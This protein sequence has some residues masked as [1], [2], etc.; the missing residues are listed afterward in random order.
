M[1]QSFE[2][3]RLLLREV[4]PSDDQKM[5]EL[6]SNPEVHRFLGNKPVKSILESR[7]MIA[8]IHW[9]YQQ[10]GIGRWA[11]VLK[12]TNEFIG[13]SG[14]KLEQNVNG[15]KQ[16]FDLG[17]RFIQQYWGKGYALEAALAFVEYGFN[18]LHIDTICAFTYA[19]NLASRKVLE[20]AGLHCVEKFLYDESDAIWYEIH[21]P[22]R[23]IGKLL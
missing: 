16:F 12:E 10:N 23:I 5:F 22:D 14:L 18:T 17:Y 3:D 9:Q 15:H 2:T 13:W 1:S 20:K 21:N 8:K 19:G 11:V 6:D 4:L 7:D